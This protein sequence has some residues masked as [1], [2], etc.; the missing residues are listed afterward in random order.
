MPDTDV[1]CFVEDVLNGSGKLSDIECAANSGE[2]FNINTLKGMVTPLMAAVQAQHAELVGLLLHYKADPDMHDPKGVSPLHMAAFDGMQPIVQH[3]L[4]ARANVD[5]R[6]RHGQ[7]PLFFAPHRSAC[8]QLGEARA[9]VNVLNYKGQS[10]LHLAAHAGLNDAVLWLA[11]HM[12]PEV[13]NTQDKHGRTAVYCAAHSNLKSTI[14]LLQEHGADVTLRPHKYRNQAAKKAQAAAAAQQGKLTNIAMPMQA[15]APPGRKLTI[16]MPATAAITGGDGEEGGRPPVGGDGENADFEVISPKRKTSELRHLHDEPT[17][18]DDEVLAILEGTLQEE[19][20]RPAAAEEASPTPPPAKPAAQEAPAAEEEAPE[21]VFE[22]R[23]TL[24]G[25]GALRRGLKSGEVSKIVDEMEEEEL[26]EV[27]ESSRKPEDDE[28]QRADEEQTKANAADEAVLKT[29]EDGNKVIAEEGEAA[30]KADE[31]DKKLAAEE[32]AFNKAEEAAEKEAPKKAANEEDIR[33]EAEDAAEKKA[34]EAARKMAEEVT[35]VAPEVEESSRKPE[36]DE[37][38][39]A[40]EEQK[41]AN[42]AE[43]A[44]LKTAEDGNKIIAEEG[45]AAKKAHE[46]DKELAAEEA[47]SN[48]AE[49]AAKK[50]AVDEEATRWPKEAPKE[51]ADEED[52]RKEVED[53]AKKKAADEEEARRDTEEAAKKIADEEHARKI[54]EEAARKRAAEQEE[55]RKKADEDANMSNAL[56]EE[57]KRIA[58]EEDQQ[59]L[60]KEQEEAAIKIQSH[61]RGKAMRTRVEKKKNAAPIPMRDFH[62]ATIWEVSL[63]KSES[64][65]KFGFS[66]SD[67]KAEFLNAR[68][69]KAAGEG[70]KVA[71]AKIATDPN[72]PGPE[73]LIV[74]KVGEKCMMEEWNFIHPDAQVRLYDR[75]TQVNGYRS[76]QEM[77][78]ELRRCTSSVTLEILRYPPRITVDLKKRD[79]ARKLGFKFE[80]PSNQ[81]LPELRITEVVKD[82]LLEEENQRR[83]AQ[84]LYHLVVTAGMR[85]EIANEAHGCGAKIAEELKT[86]DAVRMQ[87]KRMEVAQG[88]KNKVVMK[89]KTLAGLTSGSLSNS[90]GP[91]ELLHHVRKT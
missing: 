58:E 13:I 1:M 52:T 24:R 45:E 21:A 31:A 61:Q 36:D 10:A 4:D 37:Q 33:K 53:A 74:R 82:G 83:I 79:G 18:A 88:A 68:S 55:N 89:V 39:R 78:K 5:A 81:N 38:E 6:D 72:T 67:G 84:G 62:G 35:T 87:I 23:R 9:D 40:D 69:H 64:A 42:A 14:M 70:N 57:K 44:V 22:Q 25:V 76:V 65:R 51:A 80:K 75:I 11:D 34:A 49:E 59:K 56:E 54:A 47:A 28:Q 60:L 2:L 85:I 90:H 43:E 73:E 26:L 77:K 50:E 71:N 17:E 29:A 32:A 86:C 41:K 46:A 12:R 66:H 63:V 7:T 91:G 15:Q 19:A 30:K 8:S 27:E 16:E 3:L 20:L 48:K